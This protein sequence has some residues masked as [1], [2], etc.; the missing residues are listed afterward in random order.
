V[1]LD[2]EFEARLYESTW[3][4]LAE[5]GF[6][7]YE[8]SN[9]ARPGHAC[10]HNLNTW[11]MHTWVGLGPAAASQHAGW[12]GA[13]V[14]DLERWLADLAG[15]VRM[16]EDRVALTP[17]LLAEDALVFGLRMN[18]GVEL[19]PWRALAPVAPWPVID[20]MFARLEQA[21]L[22][23]REGDVVRLT[24][25]GRLLADA[26]GAEIMGAFDSV[27]ESI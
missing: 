10:R 25:R 6:A 24:G 5:A 21:E 16:T 27:T 9:F 15:G 22:L 14:A 12:R 20:E 26:V 7:Q 2:P 3:S 17:V 23:L 19:A 4:Q 8:I 1:K 18:A 11:R 13:N